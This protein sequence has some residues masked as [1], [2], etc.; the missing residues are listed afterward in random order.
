[1]WLIANSRRLKSA[2]LSAISKHPIFAAADGSFHKFE[3]LCLIRDLYLR[4][5]MA[6]HVKAPSEIVQSLVRSYPSKLKIRSIPTADECRGWYAAA[7]GQI[8]PREDQVLDRNALEGLDRLEQTIQ[9]LLKVAVPELV[10]E[11]KGWHHKTANK[12]GIFG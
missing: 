4:Q 2:T 6:S 11:V 5:A 9:L 1:M 7:S 10:A 8:A 3:A 12:A